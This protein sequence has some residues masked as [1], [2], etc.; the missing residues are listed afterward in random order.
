[1]AI[2][3]MAVVGPAPCQCFSPGENQNHV[4]GPDFLRRPAFALDPA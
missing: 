1:M 4:A 3:V 2:W